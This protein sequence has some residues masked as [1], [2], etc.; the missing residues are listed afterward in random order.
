MKT[1]LGVEWL[2]NRENPSGSGIDPIDPTGLP[3]AGSSDTGA[4]VQP[5]PAPPGAPIPPV[6]PP[7]H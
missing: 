1:R 5:P 4:T 7:A 2:E 6:T 3:P